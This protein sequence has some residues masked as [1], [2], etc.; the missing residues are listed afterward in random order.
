MQKKSFCIKYYTPSIVDIIYNVF[1]KF[2]SVISNT[3]MMDTRETE[4]QNKLWAL[5]PWGWC[6]TPSFSFFHFFL[7]WVC[8]SSKTEQKLPEGRKFRTKSAVLIKKLRLPGGINWSFGQF[9]L[10]MLGNLESNVY[11]TLSLQEKKWSSLA[12]SILLDNPSKTWAKLCTCYS[13]SVFEKDDAKISSPIRFSGYTMIGP[14]VFSWIC[15]L[16]NI[17]HDIKLHW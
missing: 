9:L 13:N 10:E 17:F 16:A 5:P 15:P 6:G 12:Q 4:E 1:S 11:K 7:G 3:P 2:L 14:L 8:N